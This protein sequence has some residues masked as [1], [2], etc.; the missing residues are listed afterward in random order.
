VAGAVTRAGAPDAVVIGAGIVGA[1]CADALATEGLRVMVLDAGFTGGGTTAAGMGHI[2]VMDDSPAQLALTA[3]SRAKWASWAGEMPAACEDVRAGTLWIAAS[4]EEMSAV[5]AKRDALAPAAV[6]SEVLDAAALARAE[7]ALR[8]GLAGALLVP[9]DRVLYPPA[10][11]RWLLGRAVARGAVLRERCAVSAVAAGAVTLD[12]ER[13]AC[14]AIVNAA[15]VD[16]PR[17]APGLPVIPRK[18]HLLITE[19]MPGVVHHQLVELGYLKSAHAM[20]A[21]S[22]AFNV[23]PRPTGQL[24]I[25]SSRELV[26]RDAS[27]NRRVLGEMLA[28]AVAFL[29]ALAQA[30][31][32][33]TWTGFRPATP[34]AL[35]L[36]GAWPAVRGL[37]IAAGHEG[38]GITTA[39]GTAAI[40]AALL[41]GRP[42]PLDAAAFDP[43]RA[44]PAAEAA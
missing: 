5:R 40:I 35:P 14:G 31:A 15:G 7:P 3:W 28:R 34:D 6:S 13:I 27:V 19:R 24:L 9:G 36:I 17:F 26:G 20:D 11:A 12:G 4:D 22:T 37:W 18:G 38:L 41:T 43:V 10:A 42:A 30:T 21:A 25:G 29:P 23:Q 32:T 39:P 1:A 8:A 44:M 33:R 16:A 2:T